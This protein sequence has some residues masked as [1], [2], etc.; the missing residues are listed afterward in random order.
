MLSYIKAAKYAIEK[1]RFDLLSPLDVSEYYRIKYRRKIGD[2]TLIYSDVTLGCGGADP[3]VIGDNCVLTGCTILGHDAS[4]NRELNLDYS[5]T[6]ETKIG[7]RCFIGFGAIILMG[8][9]IGNDCIIGA[10]AVVCNDIP[11]DS[12]VVGNPSRIIGKKSDLV[13]KRI[14]EMVEYPE[15][16]IRN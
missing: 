8:V 10:G 13:K 2:N 15:Y 6:K 3:I 11:D 5:V 12:I 4:T 14:K 16:Y 7:N 1:A 9:N